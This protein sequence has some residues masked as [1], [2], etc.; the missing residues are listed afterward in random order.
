M[1]VKTL[2]VDPIAETASA[3]LTA[4]VYWTMVREGKHYRVCSLVEDLR[5]GVPFDFHSPLEEHARSTLDKVGTEA[6]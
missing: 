4:M 1:N 6:E 2:S 5:W 3:P